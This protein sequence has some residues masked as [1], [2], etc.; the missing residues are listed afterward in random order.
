MFLF[1][2]SA[3]IFNQRSCINNSIWRWQGVDHTVAILN[4]IVQNEKFRLISDAKV[5]GTG[6]TA[7]VQIDPRSRYPH[8]NLN[9][10]YRIQPRPQCYD[11]QSI[12]TQNWKTR[13]QCPLDSENAMD[14]WFI[15][16][17]L[18]VVCA[19]SPFILHYTN[20]LVILSFFG[21]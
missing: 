16:T 14:C 17:K 8:A 21:Y 15:H 13:F 2:S 5:E 6:F 10:I 1:D 12:Q 7:P 11:S 19:S 9:D 3:K 4:A 20:L 18:H